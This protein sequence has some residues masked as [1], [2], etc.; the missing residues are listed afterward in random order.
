MGSGKQ[1]ATGT[2]SQPQFSD[3]LHAAYMLSFIVLCH[4][5]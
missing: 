1:Q 2:V 5:M 3:V 4:A